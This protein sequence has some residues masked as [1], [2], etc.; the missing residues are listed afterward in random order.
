[1]NYKNFKNLIDDKT[2][3]EDTGINYE[4]LIRYIPTGSKIV[5]E[6][7]NKSLRLRILNRISAPPL[8]TKEIPG[9]ERRLLKDVDSFINDVSKEIKINKVDK[10]AYVFITGEIKSIILSYEFTINVSSIAEAKKLA[11]LDDALS[12]YKK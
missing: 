11:K 6:L 8:T 12:F 5:T 1:M 2:I 9:A 4:N 7:K 3:N 10:D